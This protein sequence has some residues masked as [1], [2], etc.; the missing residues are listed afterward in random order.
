MSFEKEFE[1]NIKLLMR[2]LKKIMHRYPQLGQ[3]QEFEKMLKNPKE[4]PDIN[5]FLL[6]LAPVGMEDLEEVDEMF[7]EGLFAEGFKSG[8]LKYELNNAD[9]DFLKKHGIRF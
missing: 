4:I 5:I 3:S 9:Q 6:N 8:E 2:L 1:D 7:E